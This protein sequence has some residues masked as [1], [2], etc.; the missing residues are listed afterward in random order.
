MAFSNKE[1]NAVT[2][3]RLRRA[4]RPQKIVC[5]SY[6]RGARRR[7]EINTGCR[8]RRGA[9]AVKR[10]SAASA[11]GAWVQG[12]TPPSPVFCALAAP[13]LP[14]NAPRKAHYIL[15]LRCRWP[16]GGSPPVKSTA[17]GARSRKAARL[18]VFSLFGAGCETC[19]DSRQSAALSDPLSH[20][21][22]SRHPPPPPPSATLSFCAG[23][24]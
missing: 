1:N 18:G 23:I 21:S 3:L 8:A 16:G 19:P 20:P 24:V 12:V 11:D 14:Q 4:N 7:K 2:L 9:A 22:P 15:P 10:E 5:L 13:L 17:R 6:V